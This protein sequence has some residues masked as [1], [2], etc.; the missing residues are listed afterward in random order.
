MVNFFTNTPLVPVVLAS[1]VLWTSFAYGL[2]AEKPAAEGAAEA[3]A[4]DRWAGVKISGAYDE[5]RCPYCWVYNELTAARCISCGHEFPQPSG[6]YTYPPWVFVPGKGYY[7]EGTLLEPAKIRKGRFITGLVLSG[8]G[9]TGFIFSVKEERA[10]STGSEDFT[11]LTTMAAVIFIGMGAI[12]V[13]TGL[14]KSNPVYA[15]DRGELW[16]PYERPGLALRSPGSEG[17]ILKVEVTAL[18]F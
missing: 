6:E 14:K 15:L 5:L 9:V 7:R 17:I 4:E 3:G 2:P 11:P 18:S 8:F 13:A 10:A 1:L 12:L 16:E